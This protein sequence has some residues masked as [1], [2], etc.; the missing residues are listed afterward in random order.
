MRKHNGMRPQ[1]VA[2]LL[3]ICTLPVSNWS[4]AGLAN[5]LR[6]SLSEVSES[7][8]RSQLAGL[9]DASKK[10]VNRLNLFDFLTHGLRYVYP[11][12]PGSRVRGIPTAHSHP[13]LKARILSDTVYV[14]PDPESNVLGFQVDPLYTKQVEAVR[15]DENLYTLLALSDV[16]RVGKAREIKIATEELKKR[17]LYGASS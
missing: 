14:W 5:S 16:L 4:L 7:L 10:Q 13:L 1:D 8:N 9:L 12:Q 2:I 3:K 6:I 15:E 17:L 11:A